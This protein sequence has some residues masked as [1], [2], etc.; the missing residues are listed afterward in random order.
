LI[1]SLPKNINLPFYI[2]GDTFMRFFIITYD[3][4]N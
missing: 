2:F 3:K 4:E 1:G